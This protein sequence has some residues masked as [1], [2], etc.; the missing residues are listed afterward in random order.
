MP[1]VPWQGATRRKGPPA[2]QLPNFYH[3]VLT[4]ERLNVTTTKKT[5][6]GKSAP[7]QIR[8]CWLRVREKKRA[9]ALRWYGAPEWLIQPW[10]FPPRRLDVNMLLSSITLRNGQ[11]SHTDLERV[12]RLLHHPSSRHTLSSCVEPLSPSSQTRGQSRS[13]TYKVARRI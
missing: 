13:S 7:P 10:L 9:P 5:F 12:C 6:L 2:D 8:K 3:A 11:R 1:V 4:F